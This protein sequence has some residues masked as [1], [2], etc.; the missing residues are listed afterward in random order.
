MHFLLVFSK[1]SD[2]HLVFTVDSTFALDLEFEFVDVFFE[3]HLILEKFLDF[4]E[5]VADDDFELFFLDGEYFCI[6]GMLFGS[7]LF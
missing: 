7:A 5:T 2:L 6:S 4:S 3:F 1:V